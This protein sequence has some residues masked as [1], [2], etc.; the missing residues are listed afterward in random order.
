MTMSN[1]ICFKMIKSTDVSVF[2]YPCLDHY[3]ALCA[4]NDYTSDPSILPIS[5]EVHSQRSFD[6]WV[7]PSAGQAATVI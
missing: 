3:V 5:C 2:L 6:G 4:V 1:G 7:A